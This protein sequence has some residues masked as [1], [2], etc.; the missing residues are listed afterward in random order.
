MNCIPNEFY[1][2]DLC[3]V[4]D[5]PKL[6]PD[7]STFWYTVANAAADKTPEPELQIS[8][9]SD[10]DLPFLRCFSPEST[11]FSSHYPG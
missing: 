9:L 1:H 7:L 6:I 5:M 11:V 3:L 2:K 4:Q 10:R 8:N